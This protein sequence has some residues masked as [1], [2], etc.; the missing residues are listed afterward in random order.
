MKSKSNFT[1]TVI[2]TVLVFS[3]QMANAQGS[4]SLSGNTNATSNSVLGTKNAI[5]L[6]LSTNNLTHLYIDASTGNVGIGSGDNAILSYKLQVTGGAYGIYGFGSTYG[7]FG[8]GD[9]GVYGAGN[10]IG[11]YGTG[12]FGL[13]GV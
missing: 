12:I 2:V 6:R 1:I 10:T 7:L 3:F 11:T 13:Y 4:W 9:Y 5:P 8:S